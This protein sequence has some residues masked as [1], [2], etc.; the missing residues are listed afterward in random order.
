MTK[1]HNPEINVEQLMQ[2]IREEVADR[3]NASLGVE[4][5]NYNKLENKGVNLLTMNYIEN[6]LNEAELYSQVWANFPDKFNV[7]PFTLSKPLQ[8]LIL[9]IY[10]FIFKKQRVVN[11]SLSQAIRASL[12]LNQQLINQMNV[13]QE[14][15][16][17]LGNRLNTTDEQVNGLGNRLDTKDEQVNGLADHLKVTN[18]HLKVTNE[19]IKAT[20]DH[21][22]ATNEQLK[23]T[24]EQVNVL[25]NRLDMKD[26]QVKTLGEH[27]K[28]IDER[29]IRNDSYLK[30]DLSQQK[31]LI[32]LFLE[33]AKQRL[34]EPFSKDELLNFVDEDQHLL[35]AFY[36]AF[37]EQFR[38]SREDIYNR[39]NFYLPWIEKAQVG[40]KES[41]ILDVGCGRGE[42]LEL[43]RESGYTAR[44]LDLNRVMIEQCHL[45]GLE[46][47]ESDV[48]AY[49]QSLPSN[50]LGAVT[51]FHIIEHLPFE[52]LIKLLDE[53]VRV[54]HS[55]GLVIFETP[56]PENLLVGACN[57]YSDPT[58]RNPLFPPT[59]K[60]LVEQRGLVD[61]QLLR[62]SEFRITDPLQFVEANQPMSA[63]INSLIEIA[64]SNFY[65]APDFAVI[66]KKA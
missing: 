9:K 26:E 50:S 63:Q 4:I 36:V 38:G 19:Q 14:Q 8:K 33:E 35:D 20:N 1:S 2:N 49:L 22:K 29:H 46:G 5:K 41:P 57:F 44:G 18:D 27:L 16:N 34:P 64:K 28:A 11:A 52:V 54:L 59:L 6:L 58:H 65:A 62:L 32:T 12:T 56:N 48:M 40:T 31:R 17:G 15:V 10:N 24:N 45:R 60:F 23:A 53:A 3:Y 25:D 61:V 13:L 43:L 7:F 30:S 66:G 42:W 55:G 37:E 51:G 21:L 39:L 47:I